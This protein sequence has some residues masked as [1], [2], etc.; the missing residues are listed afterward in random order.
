[1]CLSIP[2]PVSLDYARTTVKLITLKGTIDIINIINLGELV[3]KP[4]YIWFKVRLFLFGYRFST[5][6]S[7]KLYHCKGVSGIEGNKHYC[8][9]FFMDTN[10]KNLIKI[11]SNVFSQIQYIFIHQFLFLWEWNCISLKLNVYLFT[12]K[13]ISGITS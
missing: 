4:Q 13:W 5:W 9:Y 6:H 1:M 2:I 7:F 8:C 12:I 10:N 3:K 11:Y